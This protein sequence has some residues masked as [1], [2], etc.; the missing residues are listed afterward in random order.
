M[1]KKYKRK[2]RERKTDYLDREYISIV[3]NPWI[4]FLRC[5]NQTTP[6]HVNNIEKISE[7]LA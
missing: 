7:S 5:N 2:H 3:G 6:T 4:Y 1:K